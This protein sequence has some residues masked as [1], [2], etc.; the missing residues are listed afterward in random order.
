MHDLGM[1]IHREGHEG[2]SLF[3]ANHLLYEILSFLPVEEKMVVISEVLHA[4]ISHRK[5]GHPLTLE[6]GI[7]RIADALDMSKGRS[8]IPY[9]RGIIDI[10]SV[11]AHAIESVEIAEGNSAR[12]VEIKIYM[13]N[14]AGIFQIDDLMQEKLKGSGVEKYIKVMAYLKNNLKFQLFKEFEF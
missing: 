5:D 2:Y 12:P 6:A 7:V 9:G 13:T 10:H 11:S 3:L 4:I 8:R 14:P 1:S